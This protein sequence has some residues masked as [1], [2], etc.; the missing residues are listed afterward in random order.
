MVVAIM[1][2]DN[3]TSPDFSAFN[4]TGYFVVFKTAYL[5]DGWFQMKLNK[6]DK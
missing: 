5:F 2:A 4:A 6:N 3:R 1:R